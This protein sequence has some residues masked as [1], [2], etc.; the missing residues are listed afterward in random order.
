M[1]REEHY[2]MGGVEVPRDLKCFEGA[3]GDT[4]YGSR[5]RAPLRDVA[6]GWRRHIGGTNGGGGAMESVSEEGRVGKGAG[7]F[8][9]RNDVPR[10]QSTAWGT[11]S[12]RE[13]LGCPVDD[14]STCTDGVICRCRQGDA[15][16][17]K[18][19]GELTLVHEDCALAQNCSVSV[20]ESTGR[21]KNE[22]GGEEH[23]FVYAPALTLL[24]CLSRKEGAPGYKNCEILSQLAKGTSTYGRTSFSI[25]ASLRLSLTDGASAVNCQSEAKEAKVSAVKP[26][27]MTAA[28]HVGEWERGGGPLAKASKKQ[29]GGAWWQFGS[30]SRRLAAVAEGK[31][32]V[33]RTGKRRGWPVDDVGCDVASGPTEGAATRAQT[34]A[35]R[36][37]GQ[38]AGARRSVREWARAKGLS[39]GGRGFDAEWAESRRAG[40]AGWQEGRGRRCVAKRAGAECGQ[41]VEQVAEHAAP[42]DGRADRGKTRSVGNHL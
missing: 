2:W 4:R 19:R 13:Q 40:G 21:G 16:S 14:A 36:E 17:L 28:L 35:S 12:G 18:A 39:D 27:V 32:G 20:G 1:P 11:F 23:T 25:I 9:G 22:T 42:F 34:N 24:H 10:A 7:G 38:K 30:W 15:P 3:G 33:G 8:M 31:A 5:E 41:A 6:G 37:V 29:R 26:I